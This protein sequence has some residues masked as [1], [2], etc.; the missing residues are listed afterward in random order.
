MLL[1]PQGLR[2]SPE[3]TR[4][5]GGNQ[6]AAVL[7]IVLPTSA[8]Q[9][10]GC[11][12]SQAGSISHYH[13]PLIGDADECNDITAIG[14]QR[15]AVAGNRDRQREIVCDLMEVADGC[16][17]DVMAGVHRAGKKRDGIAV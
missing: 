14:C 10:D 8:L 11:R 16:G 15:N 17:T 3:V 6:Q 9:S 12:S 4:T 2:W 7:S 5:A 1:A 13:V